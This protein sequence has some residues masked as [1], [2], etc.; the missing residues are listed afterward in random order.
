MI[1][2]NI[3]VRLIGLGTSFILSWL[4]FNSEFNIEY[5]DL[6]YFAATPVFIDL[7][8][9]M[10]LQ[11]SGIRTK[12]QKRF[13]QIGI[14]LSIM[15]LLVIKVFSYTI[16]TKYLLV[17]MLLCD[18]CV[19][20]LSMNGLM[21]KFNMWRQFAVI[22]GALLSCASLYFDSRWESIVIAYMIPRI[23]VN[24]I[25]LHFAKEMGLDRTNR[26][27]FLSYYPGQVLFFINNQLIY[28]VM[29]LSNP[30]VQLLYGS[31]DRV[32]NFFARPLTIF[33]QF[34]VNL[35]FEVKKYF[36]VMFVV[37]LVLIVSSGQIL[38]KTIF[39]DLEV[40]TLVTLLQFLSIGFIIPS[41]NLLY[42]VYKLNNYIVLGAVT[43]VMLSIRL[44]LLENIL[45]I[46]I[47]NLFLAFFTYIYTRYVAEKIQV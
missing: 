20:R 24:I 2:T 30:R 41:T 19:D 11:L 13:L 44:A 39:P 43:I 28:F 31:S 23:S 38:V 6:L 35:S 27:G 18:Y 10:S 5:I 45:G 36:R 32:A 3:F 22:I 40:N 29:G 1:Q 34:Y 46:A 37:I 14:L 33:G 16:W 4:L 12:F 7:G 42:S 26:Y 47:C 21:I 17:P 9:G 15:N 8:F 25:I